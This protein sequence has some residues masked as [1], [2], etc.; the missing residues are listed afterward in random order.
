MCGLN[1]RG[2]AARVAEEEQEERWYEMKR[3]KQEVALMSPV[4]ILTSIMVVYA[5]DY[6]CRRLVVRG[7]W[8]EILWRAEL[9]REVGIQEGEI[10]GTIGSQ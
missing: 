10:G 8:N 3:T 9:V 1:G 5:Q 4:S 7:R 2:V 6:R